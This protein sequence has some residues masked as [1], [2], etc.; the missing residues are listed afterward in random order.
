M[1]SQANTALPDMQMHVFN[2]ESAPR[3]QTKAMKMVIFSDDPNMTPSSE[4]QGENYTLAYSSDGQVSVYSEDEHAE[5]YV[6]DDFAFEIYVDAGYRQDQL[7][8]T[9]ADVD[10]NPNILSEL[11]WKDLDIAVIEIGTSLRL[12]SNWVMGGRFAYGTILDGKNQDSDYLGNNRTLEFS[13]SNNNADEGG[14][15]D[16]SLHVGYQFDIFPSNYRKP[17]LSIT[18]KIGYSYHAQNLKIVDGKQTIPAFGN[19]A[20]LD[21]S[22]DASWYGPWA[23]IDSE[24]SFADRVSL[25]G[26]FEYHYAFYEAT[27]NWNLRSDFAHPVS[28]EHEAEGTGYL[29]SVGSHIKLTNDLILNISVDYQDW[30]ADKK[31]I[32]RTFFSDDTIGETK[33]NGVN[34]ES[35][36]ANVGLQLTF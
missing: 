34:W 35:M 36:G 31:G 22:Y 9:I 25:F 28:F 33:F 6:A 2:T 7:D 11:T 18:P 3:K 21:S 12:P 24:L 13:R 1:N 5:A 23:G 10:G 8:W 17:F 19:F 26:S 30:K 4:K 14:T 16:A 15:I 27:A 20:G 32:N 29:A